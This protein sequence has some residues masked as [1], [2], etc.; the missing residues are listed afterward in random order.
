MADINIEVVLEIS[1][2]SFSNA[3]V[4]FVKSENLTWRSYTATEALS[5]TSSVKLINKKEFVQVALDKNSENFIVH[6]AAL[7]TILFHFSMT[8]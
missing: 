3:N 1:Y 6:I 7:G 2:L 4:K 5:F 8:S